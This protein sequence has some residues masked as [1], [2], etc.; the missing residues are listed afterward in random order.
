MYLHES[1]GPLVPERYRG[2]FDTI[3]DRLQECP[4]SGA[5]RPE[6]GPTLRDIIVEP[7]LVFYD[8]ALDVVNVLRVLHR[9]MDLKARL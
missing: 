8:L 3:L 1:A 2:S 5:P 9:K 7:Y 4:G 6:F